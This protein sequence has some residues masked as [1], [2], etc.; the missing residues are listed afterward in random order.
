MLSLH[1]TYV[2]SWGTYPVNLLCDDTAWKSQ[3]ASGIVQYRPKS[4][5]PPRICS[6]DI[7]QTQNTSVNSTDVLLRGHLLYF[8]IS[9]A[10]L[11]TLPNTFDPQIDSA[12]DLKTVRHSGTHLQW[13]YG[14][15][16]NQEFRI[17]LGYIIQS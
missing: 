10:S 16:K 12:V 17:I 7:A 2:L 1:S 14:L 9:A 13:A 15:E 6:L 8:R 4:E 3:A 5:K 11:R